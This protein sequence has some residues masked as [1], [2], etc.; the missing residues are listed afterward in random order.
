MSAKRMIA[1]L[2]AAGLLSA[3]T[4]VE[5]TRD[6]E[7]VDLRTA[8]F[9]FATQ[10]IH[11]AGRLTLGHYQT[12]LRPDYKA[13]DSPV[14]AADRDAEALIRRRIESAFPA[15]AIIGEEYGVR[16]EAA[17][18]RWYVDPIDGTKSFIRGVPLYGVLMGLEIDGRVEVGAAYFPAL[19]ELVYAAS[20][21][22]CYLNGRRTR[23]IETATLAESFLSFTNAAAFAETGQEAPWQRLLAATRYAPGWPD[24][25]GHALVAT[26]RLEIML[27]PK[28]NPWDC[29][30]FP[31]LLREAGGFF[32]SW[33]G[34]ATVHAPN[35][36]STTQTLLPHVLELLG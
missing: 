36:V 33:A 2:M 32:G 4:F 34:E 3:C 22:G 29:G 10:T 16:N 15:H 28:M 8:A 12:G 30:P 26:G 6:G 17:S 24:A 5:L 11:E 1:L 19:D 31:V 18:H 7:K 25:Y 35:A 13:D 27:D 9:D 20:G 21:E 14:T 23:V